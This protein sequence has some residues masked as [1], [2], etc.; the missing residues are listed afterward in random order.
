MDHLRTR[1]ATELPAAVALR[2][3]LHAEPRRSGDEDDTADAVC[4]HVGAEACHV[5]GTGRLLRVGPP[6]GP[7]VALRAELDAL[8]MR[9]SSG[10][11]FAAENGLAHACGHD[12]H[13]AAL[14]ALARAARGAD[15]PIGMLVLLQPREE[16]APS[17][18]ADVLTDPAF[19]AH[20]VRAVVGAHVQPLLDRG[21]AG[22]SEGPVNASADELDVVVTGSGAHGAYPHRGRD[23]VLALSQVVVA[24]HHLVSRRVDPLRSAVLTVGELHAGS[25]PN[26]IPRVARARATLRALDPRD[27]G[28]LLGAAR[29][30]VEHTAAAAGCT[31]ELTVAENEPALVNDAE[32]TRAVA[33]HLPGA[34]LRPA[35]FR[36]CGSDDFAHYCAVLPAVMLFV[37]C[38]DGR[39][40]APGLHHPG[41][42]PPD[43]LVGEVARAYLAGWCGALELF[44]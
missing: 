35:E 26:V 22:A 40:D 28:P 17:G 39:P 19:A 21:V 29:E 15:L 31:G 38:G 6:G 18:A 32:L 14:A 20:D 1:L 24:L 37:G 36:S 3:R 34:G 12:V 25:A 33:A 44:G 5:A 42:V 30:V 41:F 11:A 2:H 9:E 10:V 8:P 23:P 13:L 16:R 27:R 4:A 7:A 43:A